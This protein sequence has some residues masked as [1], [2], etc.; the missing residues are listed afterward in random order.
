MDTGV[1]TPGRC[2]EEPS[3]TCR[4]GAPPVGWLQQDIEEG[5]LGSL[6]WPVVGYEGPLCSFEWVGGM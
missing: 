5:S 4:L 2:R 6:S 1:K 3:D